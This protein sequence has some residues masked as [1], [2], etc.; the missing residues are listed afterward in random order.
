MEE[1][2][3]E[4][5]HSSSSYSVDRV[6]LTRLFTEYPDCDTF[7]RD[8]T[9]DVSPDGR[10]VWRQASHDE[11]RRWAGWDVPE[12]KQTEQDKAI[13]DAEMLVEYEYQMWVRN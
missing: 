3:G 4:L 9:S 2:A 11:L 7:L 1:A 5:A 12:G 13:K 8:F 6:L 10:R